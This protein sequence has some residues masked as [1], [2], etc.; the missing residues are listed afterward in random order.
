MLMN[1]FP[2]EHVA[3]KSAVPDPFQLRPSYRPKIDAGFLAG[4]K[5]RFPVLCL[6]SVKFSTWTDG[7]C[8]AAVRSSVYIL[9]VPHLNFTTPHAERVIQGKDG[10]LLGFL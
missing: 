2:P 7:R 3:S 1:A 5:L 4:L 10:G 8:Q 9:L 6:W